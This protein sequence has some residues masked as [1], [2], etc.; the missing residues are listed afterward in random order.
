MDSHITAAIFTNPECDPDFSYTREVVRTLAYCKV[1][2]CIDRRFRYSI[3]S[4]GSEVEYC[5]YIEDVF[6][7]SNMAIVLGGDGTILDICEKAASHD[8]PV[9]GVNLGRLGF[10]T[11][12]EK[13]D[14]RRFTEVADGNYT[15][16]V[17]MMADIKV[18]DSCISHEMRA[19]NEVVVSGG[20]ISK[21]SDFTLNCDDNQALKFRADGMIIATPTGST[22]YSLS[23]GGPVIDTCTELF[24]A[25]PICAHSLV[26]RSLVFSG[27]SVLLITAG[28]LN[29]Q[30]EFNVITDGR[31]CLKV[32]GRATIEVKKS[33]H[34]LKLIKLGKGRF[35]DI[36]A[37]KMYN[38]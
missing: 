2:A 10:L 21:I 34:K 23:A 37:N 19:L 8:M 16:D 27:N 29:K 3:G 30:E 5:T 20:T 25:T 9:F 13:N 7:N 32:S 24:C 12:V 33:S 11:S 38:G 31:E 14:I 28:D 26:S 15:T 18:T 22:A 6:K 1:T 17:R 4:I 36:L 35:Y